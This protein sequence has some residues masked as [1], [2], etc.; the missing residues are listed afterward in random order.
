MSDSH[1]VMAAEIE[2]QKS[3][4]VQAEHDRNEAWIQIKQLKHER[5]ALLKKL[6][7][8]ET[9]SWVDAVQGEAAWKE[10]AEVA[11]L[12][13][14]SQ[15]TSYE[16]LE[17]SAVQGERLCARLQGKLA[18]MWKALNT[19]DCEHAAIKVDACQD[20]SSDPR[21]CHIRQALSTDAGKLEAEVIEAA[22][23]IF[24]NPGA[25]SA[26]GDGNSLIMAVE[27]M[28]EGGE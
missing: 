28:R 14:I 20:C 7:V 2:R 24:D 16:G 18:V 3:R 21:D 23:R 5:D 17:R 22:E 1:A 8:L 25:H 13:I 4:A 6:E 19:F 12:V 15:R 11:G 26:L 10:R 27:A 9:A